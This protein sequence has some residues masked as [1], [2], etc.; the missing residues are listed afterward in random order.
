MYAA[1]MAKNLQI[2]NVPDDVHARVRARAAA[3]GLSVSDYLLNQ[4]TQIAKRPTQAEVFARAARRAR[5]DGPTLDD[6]LSAI[7]EGRRE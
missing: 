7:E 5:E 6:I 2:R 1:S 4:I 3:E